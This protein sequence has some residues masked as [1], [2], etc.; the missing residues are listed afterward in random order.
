MH[1]RR[2]A[3]GARSLAVSR[4]M[5]DRM[6]RAR[7]LGWSLWLFTALLLWCNCERLKAHISDWASI[8][9]PVKKIVRSQDVKC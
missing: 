5:R 4:V 9:F 7:A 8:E 3:H 1:D 2:L 6:N